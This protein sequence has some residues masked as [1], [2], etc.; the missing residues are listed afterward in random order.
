MG[1]SNPEFL[2][3]VCRNEGS[4]HPVKLDEDDSEGVQ[5][6]YP[7]FQFVDQKTEEEITVLSSRGSYPPEYHVG[8]E[9]DILYDPENPHDAKIKSF[10]D[11][12]GGPLI[13][14]GLGG[15]FLAVGLITLGIAFY[16]RAS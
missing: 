7:V 15:I 8:Q 16:R 9:V 6:A 2:G 14:M 1:T 13:L 10:S 11:I 4:C 5:H 3:S 12:W